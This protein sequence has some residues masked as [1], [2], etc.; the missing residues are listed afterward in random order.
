MSCENELVG[1]GSEGVTFADPWL[2]QGDHIGGV[3]EKGPAF[4][5]FELEPQAGRE[6]L[7]L[8]GAPGFVLRQPRLPEQPGRAPLS[9]L[10]LLALGQ[11]VQISF[12]GQVLFGRFERQVGKGSGHRSQIEA[13]EQRAQVGLVVHGLRHG[14]SLP[15]MSSS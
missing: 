5:A 2:A 7:Q 14:F 1:D 8:E 10:L 15:G 4:E 9:A 6:P 11:F 3:L 12:V 13:L